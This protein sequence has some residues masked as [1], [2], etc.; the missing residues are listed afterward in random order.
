M[1]IDLPA[2]TATSISF[3]FVSFGSFIDERERHTLLHHLV[4]R[5]L[6]RHLDLH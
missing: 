2:L 6:L 1:E 3:V 4:R 5:I